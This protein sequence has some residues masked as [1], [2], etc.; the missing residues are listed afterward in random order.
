MRRAQNTP[1]IVNAG[2]LVKISQDIV[3]ECRIVFGAINSDFI[4]ASKT[5][6]LIIGKKLYDNDILKMI[7]KSLDDEL[8]CTYIPPQ[9]VPL[10]RKNLAISL[11]YKVK[12]HISN[13]KYSKLKIL[14][15]SSF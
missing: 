6:T 11:F 8:E 15:Y 13:L 1:A 9:P 12:S 3:E 10:Y 4:H 7:Y 14:Y 5:E 2:F